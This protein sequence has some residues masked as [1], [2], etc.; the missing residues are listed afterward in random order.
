MQSFKKAMATLKPDVI[1]PR[2]TTQF[3]KSLL[4]DN[5]EESDKFNVQCIKNARTNCGELQT[6]PY[7]MDNIDVSTRVVWNRFEY[8]IYQTKNGE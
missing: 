2:S 8:E 4:Y 1:I 3:V 7:E 6:F 5:V